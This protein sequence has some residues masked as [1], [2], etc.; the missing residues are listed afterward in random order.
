MPKN[1]EAVVVYPELKAELRCSTS[2]AGPLTF[3]EAKE[4]IGWT[5]E[6]SD[7]STFTLKDTYNR[8][9]SLAN[10][11]TN[12]PLKLPIA[13]RYSLEWL[14][15]VWHVNL[16][17]VV[18]GKSGQLRDGQHRIV[19][20]ILAEQQ[21]QINPKQWGIEPLV[22][23]VL[24]GFGVEDTNEVADSFDKGQAR[25]LDDVI[26]RHEDFSSKL[27][28]GD[29]KKMAKILAGALRLV[30][31]RTGG[32]TV[33]SAPHFP[34]SEAL[35][36]YT[37]NPGILKSVN[38]ITTLD[39]GEKSEKLIG[40]LISQAYAAALHYLMC[41]VDKAKATTF[42]TS[43]ATGEGLAK[44]SPILALRSYLLRVSAGSG[45][46]RDAI[47]GACVKAWSFYLLDEVA[48]TKTIAVKRQKKGEKF[49]L[50]ETP[51][52]GG[53]DIEVE[54]VKGFDTKHFLI[55]SC[56]KTIGQEASF[57]EI[58]KHTGLTKGKISKLCTEELTSEKLVVVSQY[59]PAEGQKV[60]P[61]MVKLTSKGLKQV[62]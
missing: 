53:V 18:F 49:I 14:R 9:I 20:F 38:L 55:L 60:A 45:K 48:T 4:L 62:S 8:K 27:S 22:M 51:R 26:Y 42:W 58:S 37:K 54:V 24:L 61:M 12:R 47:V 25:S 30:W 59:E 6:D 44:G 3:E 32:Q 34:H 43:F 23:E 17:T 1:T 50:S 15:K 31:I 29:Q 2:E 7:S 21:R 11:P 19:G 52:L 28:D 39:R 35:E 41:N 57:D 5:E 13:K 46:E 33:S 10:N 16:E 40:S 36:F 56:L